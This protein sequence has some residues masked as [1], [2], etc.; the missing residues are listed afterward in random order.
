MPTA[1]ADSGYTGTVMA[2]RLRDAI[3][4]IEDEHSRLLIDVGLAVDDPGDRERFWDEG[5]WIGGSE[6]WKR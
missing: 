3:R 2:E 6:W 5:R 4:V 1:F